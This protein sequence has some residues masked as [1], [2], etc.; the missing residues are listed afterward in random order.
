MVK[1]SEKGLVMLFLYQSMFEG[2][3]W[4][5]HKKDIKSL[6]KVAFLMIQ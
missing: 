5:S 3:N 4:V 1:E 6:L 2:G